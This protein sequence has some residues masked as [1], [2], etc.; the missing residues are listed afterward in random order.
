MSRLLLVRHAEAAAHSPAGDSDRPLTPQ[1]TA[2]AARMGNYLR[3][4]CL[5]PGRALASPALRARATLDAILREL[6]RKP[7]SCELDASL[8]YADAGIFLEVL[9]RT[10]DAVETLLIV[11]HNP[12]VWQF[13]RFLVN[14]EDG[15]PG[16]FPA[17]SLA[18][19]GLG[20]GGWSGAGAGSG[21]LELFV[22]FSG[23]QID[24][25]ASRS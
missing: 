22:D 2:D 10:E 1:G 18:V 21:S 17:P 19:I 15:F 3:Q 9:A 5:L 16:H 7:A 12:G 6:P 14:K 11:G 23:T 8:Y 4:S 13:A 20:C 24:D 25:L